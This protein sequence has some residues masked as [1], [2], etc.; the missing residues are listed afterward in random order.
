[1][2]SEQRE[3]FRILSGEVNY[4]LCSFCKY[5]SYSGTPCSVG[6]YE[7]DHPLSDCNNFPNSN[8][9]LEPYE[10]CWAFR[11]MKDYSVEVCADIVGTIK[12]EGFGSTQWEIMDNGKI[13]VRGVKES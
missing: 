3:I 12:V 9:D 11:P 1:M 5:G 13:L 7:C 2:K 6:E 10:D 8:Y 4:L